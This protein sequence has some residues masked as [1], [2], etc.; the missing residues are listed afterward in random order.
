[1][2]F[3]SDDLI[4]PD[5][6]ASFE[7][8]SGSETP[9]DLPNDYNDFLKLPVSEEYL[10][11]QTLKATVIT[12]LVYCEPVVDVFPEPDSDDEFRIEARKLMKEIRKSS[13]EKLPE[14]SSEK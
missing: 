6:L 2:R 9:I 1:M 5:L 8:G 4:Q 10:K 14:E 3:L 7:S 11:N 12:E 13:E